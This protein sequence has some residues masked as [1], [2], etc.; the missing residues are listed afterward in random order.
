MTQELVT[1]ALAPRPW[2]DISPVHEGFVLN[3]VAFSHITL[4]SPVTII[5]HQFMLTSS[6]LLAAKNFWNICNITLFLHHS[7]CQIFVIFWNVFILRKIRNV[8][9]CF[10]KRADVMVLK[11]GLCLNMAAYLNEEIQN[12]FW[13]ACYC[14]FVQKCTRRFL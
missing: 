13:G 5:P 6:V 8:Y 3:I 9:N 12:C 11:L 1:S 7:P 10:I 14:N 2:F 4:V